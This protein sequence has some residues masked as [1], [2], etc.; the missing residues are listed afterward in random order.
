MV[1][2]TKTT[3]SFKIPDEW[4]LAET[5]KEQHPDWKEHCTTMMIS[6]SKQSTYAVVNGAEGGQEEGE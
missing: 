6:Y 5:F 1:I 4:K 2:T 3:I